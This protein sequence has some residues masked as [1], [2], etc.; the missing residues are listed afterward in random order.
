MHFRKMQRGKTQPKNVTGLLM[1]HSHAFLVPYFSAAH[2][3][4]LHLVPQIPV[5]HFPFSHFPR[6]L[7]N[8]HSE[9][10]M[11]AGTDFLY[12][13]ITLRIIL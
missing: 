10:Y 8:C 9:A 3:S 4:P 13:N 2:F 12:H 6:P 5:S 7:F 1:G 11:I